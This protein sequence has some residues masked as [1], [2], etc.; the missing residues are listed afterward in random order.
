MLVSSVGKQFSRGGA[1]A[2]KNCVLVNTSLAIKR[3]SNFWFTH[4]T[5]SNE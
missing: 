1:K 4:M 2:A 5:V 3:L